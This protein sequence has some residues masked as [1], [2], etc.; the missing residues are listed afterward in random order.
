M[1]YFFILSL[2]CKVFFATGQNIIPNPSF[3][4]INLCELKIPCSPAAWYSVSNYPYG[5]QNNL[6]NP[7]EGKHCLDFLIAYTHEIRAYWQTM[8]LA[9]LQEQGNYIISFYVYPNNIELNPSYFGVYLSDTLLHAK[10]DTMI[11]KSRYVSIETQHISVPQKGWYKISLPYT[12][13]GKEK[14]LLMGNFSMETNESILNKTS[15]KRKYIEYYI[16]EVSLEPANKKSGKLFVNKKRLD[17]LY[18][19]NLRHIA[20]TDNKPL[21]AIKDIPITT[22]IPKTD[23]LILGKVNF[24]FDSDKL[25]NTKTINQYFDNIPIEKIDKIE[26]MGFTDRIGT[27]EYNLKLSERRALSVKEYLITTYKLP[28]NIF[29]VE[30]K[31]IINDDNILEKN[32]RVE[33]RIF[34]L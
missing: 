16:D 5:Y 17:S 29:M 28:T 1:K 8:L 14:Y 13:T 31:G 32:R 26:I 34:R 9:N 33:L 6:P 18:A 15:P 23:T 7:F 2:L 4:I 11:Q 3:E 20:S 22:L 27:K 12:A 24:H 25:I 30:G 21:T 19:T 10:E